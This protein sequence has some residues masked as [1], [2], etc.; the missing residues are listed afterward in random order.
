MSS[1]FKK[2]ESSPLEFKRKFSDSLIFQKESNPN[3]LYII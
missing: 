3:K 1:P 2:L